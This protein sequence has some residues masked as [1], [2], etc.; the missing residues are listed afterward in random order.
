M[1]EQ[2]KQENDARL[3]RLLRYR[4]ENPV[5]YALVR[6]SVAWDELNSVYAKSGITE[7]F[8]WKRSDL[9]ALIRRLEPIIG[10][11]R[12]AEF[13]S[14]HPDKVITD[15]DGNVIKRIHGYNFKY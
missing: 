14:E 15:K 9:K 11:E 13:R 5:G 3:E 1:T 7:D 2:Q 4:R 8:K 12:L 6:I 10:S